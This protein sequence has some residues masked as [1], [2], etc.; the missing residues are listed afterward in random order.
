MPLTLMESPAA[1]AWQIPVAISDPLVKRCL[2]LFE[3]FRSRLD[4]I[5]CLSGLFSFC[6]KLGGLLAVF[7]L[8]HKIDC[9]S[10][11]ACALHWPVWLEFFSACLQ[12]FCLPVRVFTG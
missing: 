9:A 4:A 1:Y 2:G 5:P 8:L 3:P 10:R 12:V 11:A 6:A 7:L